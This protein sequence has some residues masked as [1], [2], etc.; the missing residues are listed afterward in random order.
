MLDTQLQD[1]IY[2]F[3]HQQGVV[4]K[5]DENSTQL[6][7][8]LDK[9]KLIIITTLQKFPWVLDKVGG[10]GDKRFALILDEAH[11]SQAGKG[12]GEAARGADHQGQGRWQPWGLNCPLH[13]L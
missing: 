10:L 6:A 4:E 7:E 9:G 2:Q 11:S 8:R 12:G 5:I 13:G 3:D 1:T